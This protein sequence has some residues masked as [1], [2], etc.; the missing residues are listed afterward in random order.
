MFAGFQAPPRCP[1]VSTYSNRIDNQ[2]VTFE[3]TVANSDPEMKLTYNWS[4]TAGKIISGRGTSKIV[5][6]IADLGSQTITATVTLTGVIRYAVVRKRR[7]R[8]FTKQLL[9]VRR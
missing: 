5:V 7:A 8:F 1:T 9:N 4:V 3:G 6:D 2:R